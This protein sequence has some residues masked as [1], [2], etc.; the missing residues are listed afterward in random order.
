MFVAGDT[1]FGP[2]VTDILLDNPSVGYFTDLSPNVAGTVSFTE[3]A[4]NVQVEYNCVPYFSE[5]TNLNSYSVGFDLVTGDVTLGSLKAINRPNALNEGALCMSGG[6]V[7][8]ATDNGATLFTAGGS[9]SH[10]LGTDAFYDGHFDTLT[11]GFTPTLDPNVN[12]A[13]PTTIVFS[14]VVPGTYQ[15]AGF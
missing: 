12:S 10:P 15:W 6:N 11:N 7:V 1:D 5:G 14:V 3:T 8:G 4:T 2:S 9:G 13:V